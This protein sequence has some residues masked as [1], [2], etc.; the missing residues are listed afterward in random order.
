MLR[1][2]TEL[3]LK[4]TFTTIFKLAYR[5]VSWPL[6]PQNVM[7]DLASD[8]SQQRHLSLPLVMLAGGVRID[9]PQSGSLG[10]ADSPQTRH[11]A[12][13]IEEEK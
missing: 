9:L 11:R 4:V 8:S 13:Q 1:Q 2:S 3:Y 5:R 7:G 10:G 12:K 6:L